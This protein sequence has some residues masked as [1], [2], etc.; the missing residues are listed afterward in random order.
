[1]K[2]KGIFPKLFFILYVVLM[3]W[4]LFGQRMFFL[5]FEDYTERLMQNINIIPFFTIKKYFKLISYTPNINLIR[6]AVVN[7]AGNVVMFIP[8]GYL[9][10]LVNKKL[11]SFFLCLL[12]AAAIIL[13]VEAI[14]LVT[15]LGS[16]DI[17]DLILNLAGVIIGYVLYK[18]FT[19]ISSKK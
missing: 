12:A 5:S 15:L 4:L 9:L 19:L 6:H 8:L 18:V 10:P 2:K 17:D 1:M 7:L 16:C 14:Q 3:L 11:K 13:A